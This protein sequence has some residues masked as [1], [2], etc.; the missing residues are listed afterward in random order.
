MSTGK[1]FLMS[2]DANEKAL[3]D[4]EVS[5][6]QN[7]STATKTTTDNGILVFDVEKKK[8]CVIQIQYDGEAFVRHMTIKSSRLVRASVSDAGDI[9]VRT[10]IT[11]NG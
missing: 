5:V 7:G 4:M 9:T 3:P 6:S 11:L 1:L 10:F 2:Y 8:P